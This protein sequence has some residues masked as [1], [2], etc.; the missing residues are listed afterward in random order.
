MRW[1]SPAASLAEVAASAGDR[2]WQDRANNLVWIK[3]VGGMP[4][5]NEQNLIVNSDDWLYRTVS[6][7]ISAR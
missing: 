6:I 5:P 4:M 3:Y 1:F 7:V 2:M